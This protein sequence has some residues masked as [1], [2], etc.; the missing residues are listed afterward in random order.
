MLLT[1]TPVACLLNTLS[2]CTS[3]PEKVFTTTGF[4][5]WKHAT[6]SK[7]MLILSH[8]NC[9]SHKQ[10]VI[11]WEQF[12]ATAT[13]GSVAEQLGSGGAEQIRKNR[14]YIKS[15]TE[16]LLLCSKQEISF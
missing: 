13:A 9:I 14:H 6:G 11:A 2:T 15:V 5:D 1:A 7:G 10:A 3:R 12:K 16:V 4:R 8:T